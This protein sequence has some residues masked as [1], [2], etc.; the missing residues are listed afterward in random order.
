[1]TPD[2]Y[3][4]PAAA[5]PPADPQKLAALDWIGLGAAGLLIVR[6][7]AFGFGGWQTMFR[8]MGSLDELP[9]LTRVTL[10]PWV[11]PV[12][13]LPVVAAVVMFWRCRRKQRGR[14][15]WLLAAVV[16]GC[17]AFAMCIV[18]VYLPIFTL[19]GKIR[20]E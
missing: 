5:P 10:L 4:A 2:P 12:L 6:L 3:A 15:R 7:L 8:D 19:A 11:P 14:R 16:L 20:A 9:W 17:V 13:A 18:A 1:M